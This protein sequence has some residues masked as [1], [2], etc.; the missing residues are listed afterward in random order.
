[1]VYTYA[2]SSCVM[3]EISPVPS[4]WPETMCPP[5]RP[6]ATIARSK[7]TMLPARKLPKEERRSVSCITSALKVPRM[8]FALP[9]PLA[10]L[11]A[12]SPCKPKLAP[13]R[14]ASISTTVK[15]TPFTAM[16]S[17]AFVASKTRLAAMVSRA[18]SR[19]RTICATS[20]VSSIKPVNIEIIYSLI[21]RP[22]RVLQKSSRAT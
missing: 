19:P 4:M 2:I 16:L 15:H 9:A 8:R 13:P 20:P 7:F 3:Q 6:P 21:K 14:A 10:S 18:E 17:P 5:N 11:S 1:M 22:N 12:I